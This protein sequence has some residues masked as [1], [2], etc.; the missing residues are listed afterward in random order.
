MMQNRVY[1]KLSRGEC[2]FG[3]GY[4]EFQSESLPQLLAHCGFDFLFIDMEHTTY[5]MEAVGRIV[6]AA[7]QV[8]L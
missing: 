3:I 6:W 1:E 4:V 8:S 5:S 7:R 2:V